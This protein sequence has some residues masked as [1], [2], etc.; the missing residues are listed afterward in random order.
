[1]TFPG[2]NQDGNATFTKNS[3]GFRLFK[4]E[5]FNWGTFDGRVWTFSPYGE[6][7]LLTGEVGSGKSTL[8]DALTTLLISPRK[9]AYNKAADSSAKERTLA[10]YV[11]G[12]F[13]LKKGAEGTGQPEC[14]RNRNSYS[15]LLSTFVDGSL[16][17]YVTLAQFFWFQAAQNQPERFY[18]VA[19]R[20]LSIIK[21]FSNFEKNVR[22]LKSRLKN[23]DGVQVF[24]DYNRYSLA[25]RPK[26]GI[27][28]EQ[29]LDLFQQT[30]SMKKV[31]ALTEFVRTNML[32]DPQTIKDVDKLIEHFH[33]LNSAHEAVLK[34]KDQ[35]ARLHPIVEQGNRHA[36][37]AGDQVVLESAISALEF[38]I[39][40]QK[41]ALQVE[42]IRSLEQRLALVTAKREEA[43]ADREKIENDLRE[44]DREINVNGG[45]ALRELENNI[46]AIEGELQRRKKASDSYT[47]YAKVLKLLI[48]DSMETFVSNKSKIPEL[49]SVEQELQGK[50]QKDF[51]TAAAEKS[52]LQTELGEINGELESLRSRKSSLPREQIEKRKQLCKTLA[53]AEE[54]LPFVGE[55][56]EVRKDEEKWEGAIERL[57]HN[58]A[59]SMLVSEKYYPVVAQWVDKTPLGMRLVYYRVSQEKAQPFFGQTN[60]L[61]AA[62]KLN[63]KPNTPF[64]VWLTKEL[65]QRFS[66]ICCENMDQFRREPQAITKFGQIK[67]RGNRH[68]KD[69]RSSIND[70]RHFVLGFSNQ[71][72]I[73]ALERNKADLEKD[74]QFYED[75]I[76]ETTS[77]QRD[78]QR[79][80]DALGRL[81]DVADFKEI[82]VL[83]VQN[84]L[85]ERRLRK[86][87]LEKG[88]DLLKALQAQR[89]ELEEKQAQQKEVIKRAYDNEAGVK[90]QLKKAKKDQ[91]DAQ[92]LANQASTLMRNQAYPYLDQHKTEVW[93]SDV[94]TLENADN[95]RRKYST[96]LEMKKSKVQSEMKNLGEKIVKA[97]TDYTNQYKEETKEIDP[98]IKALPEFE[99]ILKQLEEDGLP[100]FETRF[101]QLLHENT[102]NQIALFQAK[103]KQAQDIMKQR[104]DQINTSLS[105]I[106]YNEGR[107]IRLEYD[108]TYDSDVKA[109]RV[110]L[111]SCT[112][113][114][115]TGSEDEQYAE[116]KFLQVKAIIERFQG[117]PGETESDARWTRKVIDVRNWFLFAAS[118]RWRDTDEEYEH[119]TDSGGK[120]GGQKEKLAYTI[121][122]ASLVYHF[123][124]EGQQNGA[125]SF[126]FVVIDEAF[127]KSSDESAR[128]GL[129]LF[130]NLDLQLMIVTPL[131]K[132][133][134][135]AQFI[136]HVGF[137]HHDDIRHKSMLRN[138]SIDEY[139]RER[140][141]REAM[142]S[143]QMV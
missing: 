60:P 44:M 80:M 3:P 10:S 23:Q 74:K 58:F 138:I 45:N 1:M 102:I 46:Q 101:K 86:I 6:T 53:I 73:D 54:E 37:L 135:I 84:D 32:E 61:S 96:W 124:L 17:Q 72:K 11:R 95:L 31:E 24:D 111:R 50:L 5:V 40:Q 114:V 116:A 88:N 13:G 70:R 85:Q 105:T 94:V 42:H 126:R 82:D 99:R 9:V 35:I 98:S 75:E 22:V 8:V 48:P 16:S 136:A 87:S 76:Q 89:D 131:L 62:A 134:T 20:E 117:R 92:E 130:R 91:A 12:Y 71:R 118:E 83:S 25:F 103:L 128:Y 64:G 137:V 4:L 7:A 93:K 90:E 107:Y 19:D 125:L 143:V 43:E 41:A 132:I 39:A 77:R 68:E 109:F 113:G 108:E 121:L 110:Q 14:L 104:I 115:L 67:S 127:L 18:I 139:E 63:I 2:L 38:W 123:G 133:P 129:Q 100:K 33:D 21:D 119:Y 65:Q 141:E 142:R 55:L 29:A 34:A 56:L 28:Q 140:K 112:E 15:V 26:L 52:K 120:S 49:E 79:R 57:L 97:L 27:A 59:L 47:S 69:D 66:H 36:C 81:G 51:E 78:S 122:A 106:D 30:I